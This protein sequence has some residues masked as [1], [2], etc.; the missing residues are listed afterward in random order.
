[1]KKIF[2][3][4]LLSLYLISSLGV[5]I[6]AHYCGGNLA[7]LAI[8]ENPSCCCDDVQENKKD[9]CC[10]NENK[11]LKITADQ[12]KVEF[13]EKKFQSVDIFSPIAISEYFVKRSDFNA[14]ASIAVALPSKPEKGKR[15]PAYKR[16]HSFL[17]YS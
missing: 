4:F 5:T 6:S 17:F 10:K 12:N 9:D 13:S 11:S 15:I 3:I 14:I 16:N 7:A 8:F 2:S 1:M